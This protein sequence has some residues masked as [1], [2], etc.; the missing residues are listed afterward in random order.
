MSV[1]IPNLNGKKLVG[2]CLA[3][4]ERQSFKDFEVI[5]VDNGSADGSVGYVRGEFPWLDK[6][7]ENTSNLGFAKACNQGIELS[8][9]E[10]IAL[11]NNDTE[12]HP[13]WLAELVRVAGENPD[14]GMFACKTL[15]Y[16]KRD[17]IDTAGHLIYPDGL[18]RG[19]GR[20]EV[21]RGQYDEK[22]D[23]F[24]PSG[25]AA[26]YRK[27]MFDE[28][29]LFDEHHFAYGDDTDVG[30]RGRLAGWKC[31]FVPGSIVYHRYSMTTGEYSP[32]KAYLVERNRIWIVWKYFPMKYLLLSPFY[33]LARYI[34]QLY[35]VLTSKGAAGKSA[36]QYSVWSLVAGV[37]K[38]YVSAFAGAP[39]VWGER[40]RMMK[41]KKV[42][43]SEI[44]R[45]FKDYRMSVREIALKD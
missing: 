38:A 39:R 11:L 13:S 10:Y 43:D 29:G 37:I 45:W 44:D 15:A 31:I 24:F 3:S 26:L 2:E 9:G 19:R 20:L 42:P 4:L 14:A 21:D 35:G 12:A 1:I 32:G 22:T 18:N 40:K 27:K 25:C 33:A 36:S 23:V 5:L 6:I 30:I 8:S 34:F 17:I 7:I 16:D 28:I 41:L